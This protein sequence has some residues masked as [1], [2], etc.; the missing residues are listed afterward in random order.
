[1]N[2]RLNEYLRELETHL[3][4][5]PAADR[6]PEIAEIAA[7]LNALMDAHI[8]DGQSETDAANAA[9][10]QFGNAHTIAKP[11]RHAQKRKRFATL[12][13]TTLFGTALLGIF[14]TGEQ[15]FWRGWQHIGALPAPSDQIV[16]SP[17]RY[18]S[19]GLMVLT[20]LLFR[21]GVR[22]IAQKRLT[23]PRPCE[24]PLCTLRLNLL[25]CGF[26]RFLTWLPLCFAVRI[27]M[28]R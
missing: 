6:A 14:G 25:F 20:V 1:M 3:R 12:R 26:L 4:F 10:A 7:H 17:Q 19:V 28:C 9:L 11:L 21:Y 27:I 18:L 15:I 2:N 5:L 22:G 13:N 23:K 16:R 8:S 24:R